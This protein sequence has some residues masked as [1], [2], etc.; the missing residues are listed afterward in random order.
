MSTRGSHSRIEGRRIY[1]EFHSCLDGFTLPPK[2]KKRV[3]LISTGCYFVESIFQDKSKKEGFF[4]AFPFLMQVLGNSS[5]KTSGKARKRN[6]Q[7]KGADHG[8]PCP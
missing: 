5:F 4:D 8:S 1:R 2:K 7:V 6:C 3:V